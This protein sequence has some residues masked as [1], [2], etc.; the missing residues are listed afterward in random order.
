MNDREII[1]ESRAFCAGI[2]INTFTSIRRGGST[3]GSCLCI[4]CRLPQIMRQFRL[5]YFSAKRY[6]VVVQVFMSQFLI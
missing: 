5:C 3:S 1:I 6:L 4:S 2:F